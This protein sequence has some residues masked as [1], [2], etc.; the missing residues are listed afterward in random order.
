MI[1]T[2]FAEGNRA[3]K[4]VQNFREGFRIAGDDLLKGVIEQLVL[5]GIEA[6]LRDVGFPDPRTF[7]LERFGGDR[8]NMAEQEKHL[9]RQFVSRILEPIGLRMLGD[10]ETEMGAFDTT[11][12]GVPFPDFF[13]L[14]KGRDGRHELPDQKLLDFVEKPLR[15]AGYP[16]FRLADCVFTTDT[17]I[18]RQVA[19]GVL[20]AVFGNLAEA[21]HELDCDVVLLSGR[22][23]RLPA[24]VDLFM[25]KLAV[26]PNKVIPLHLYQAGNWYPF[27]ARDNR[28]IGD[29]KTTTA[30]GGMLC[31]LAEG[32]LT[33]FTLYT[34]RLGLRSTARYIGEL[35]ISG[36]LLDNKVCFRDVDLDKQASGRD[37]VA[38]ITYYAPMRLGYRQLPL[39]RWIATP[40][41]RLRM[42][43]GLD[44]SQFRGP[45]QITLERAAGVF[46]DE[47][48]P[49]ALILSESTKEEFQIMEAVDA[50][51]IDV[52]PKLEL[53]LDTLA[54]EQGYWLDTG[55][56]TI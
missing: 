55:I 34:S 23:S 13:P 17:G 35:E 27:R 48:T 41:Y 37:Q 28:R 50:N 12:S 53:V 32:Q 19:A 43:P 5:R 36:Q 47:D 15:D 46:V 3:I 4:P 45:F 14:S 10:A 44:A 24:V 11:L 21:I 1:T 56:L 25:D 33:N 20:D 40:L 49:D 52:R 2:Y 51:G 22:P 9:R 39:D 29:P 6:G 7:L 16:Q 8:A 42:K 26:A 18:I 30:V 31:A 38:T 54:S